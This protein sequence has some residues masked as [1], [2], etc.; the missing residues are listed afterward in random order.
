MTSISDRNE[1][2]QQ[3]EV[4][5]E[6]KRLTPAHRR[7]VQT[8]VDNN[9]EI[10]YMSSV[11][12]AKLANV[13]QPSLSRFAT[14]LGFDGFIEMR[15]YFRSLAQ[16]GSAMQVTTQL[17]NKYVA[18]AMAEAANVAALASALGD[19]AQIDEIGRTLAESKQLVVLG[20][21]ASK[22]QAQQF[23]YF[24]SKIHPNVKVLTSGG[25]E[26]EDEIEHASYAG[27][28]CILA[29]A[30]P[31]YPQETIKALKLAKHLGLKVI[32]IADNGFR[33][34]G[35][36]ADITL[37]TQVNSTLVFDSS[38]AS[39]VLLAVLLDA[40]CDALPNAETRLEFHD[41]SSRSRK[42]FV[43]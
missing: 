2:A 40:I 6:G 36:V 27:A 7:V 38:A 13:S 16:Q 34:Q 41:K 29:F 31:L 28:S 37:T 1:R 9:S 24:A 26:L 18:A 8:L 20:L 15:N 32:V 42:V 33:F 4:L 14:A 43:R 25:S 22:G 5:L 30:L 12:L 39:N 3:L 35:E 17:Q 21:R 23:G 19:K 10:G 11:E